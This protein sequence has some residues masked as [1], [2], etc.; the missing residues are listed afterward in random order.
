MKGGLKFLPLIGFYLGTY[1]RGGVFVKRTKDGNRQSGIK[2]A[3]EGRGISP[4]ASS[5]SLTPVSSLEENKFLRS[6]LFEDDEKPDASPSVKKSKTIKSLERIRRWRNESGVPTWLVLYPEGTRF[7][8]RDEAK[9][10]KSRKYAEF[11]DLEPLQVRSGDGGVVP[12]TN[13]KGLKVC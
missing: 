9:I 6:N 4:S 13:E 11:N 7:D 3:F 2:T 8:P 12:V 1:A 5:A 10:E